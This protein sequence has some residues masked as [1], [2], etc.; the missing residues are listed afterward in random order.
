MSDGRAGARLPESLKRLWSQLS[1][2]RRR[3]FVMV[4]AGMVVSAFAEVLSLGAI[5]PFIGILT[6]PGRALA[7][8]VVGAIARTFGYD[9][10]A[11]LLLPIT[12]LFV[13]VALLS[14]A[15]RTVV[16]WFST[17]LAFASGADLS[18]EVYRRTLYQPYA[19]HVG[20][21]S[22]EIISGITNNVHGV[23]FGILVPALTLISSVVLLV[24][25]TIALF[26]FDPMVAAVATVGFG[27]CYGIVNWS[28]RRRLRSN[29]RRIVAEQTQVIKALQEGLGG[30]RDVL[31]DGS[32]PVLCDVYGRADT[33][34]R[35]AEGS[36]TF[37]SSSPRFAMEAL[38]MVLIAV[39]AYGL[40]LR[41]G[42]IASALPMLGA[43]ALGAQ[44]LLPALQQAHAAWSGI[45]GHQ[46]SLEAAMRLLEQSVAAEM[47]RDPPAPLAFRDAVRFDAVRFRYD[48]EG[49]WILDGLDLCI[50]K[51]SC[52]G[53]VGTTGSG[54]S[55]TLDLIMGLLIPT[56]GTI[57]VD[58][59]PLSGDRVRAWQRSVAHVPQ[60]IYL[61]DTT[62]A[63][64]IAFGVPRGS[65]DM[66]R[67]RKAAQQARIADFV[68]SL[69]GGYDADVG[70]RGIRL[71]GGQR[72]RI[73]IARALYK[74]A[75][76]LIF[77][78]AT[79]ALDNATEQSVMDAIHGLDSELTILIIAHRLTTVRHCD[80]VVQLE[81]GRVVA[82]GTYEQLIEHSAY[83]RQMALA[84]T[85]Y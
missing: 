68:E 81:N 8:P 31:L 9:T 37:L 13:T 35:Q 48:R 82:Q 25:I 36:N 72:Q 42:G 46:A 65:I 20:R 30:I 2:R 4:L 73:G 61:A 23:V 83:F 53:F 74:N 67:V 12:V 17:R 45:V 41:P 27:A 44:R 78:E 51:G 7:N 76:V 21:N 26:V 15:V 85:A 62:M 16:L 84:A 34:L 55:T 5:L 49:P 1:R 29:S 28:S 18:R 14:G 11:D 63:Q 54:K 50:R 32:Q 57:F 52:V 24:A 60:F 59:H 69:P 75:T 6:A 33:R 70:E 22:S 39:M 66:E 3:Q 77:D 80:T 64:N 10:P 56:E 71:S 79:S 43:L 38:G 40:A 19:V 58:G 47:M